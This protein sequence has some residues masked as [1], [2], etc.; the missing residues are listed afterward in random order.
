MKVNVRK[1]RK[2]IDNLKKDIDNVSMKLYRVR[3]IT[4]N[5]DELKEQLMAENDGL[6]LKYQDEIFALSDKLF[7][8]KAKLTEANETILH[9]AYGSMSVNSAI[10]LLNQ[11]GAFE[12]QMRELA[13]VRESKRLNTL[14]Q[15]ET[16]IK[17]YDATPFEEK[18]LFFRTK[19]EDL[20]EA[21]DTFNL[22]H[23]VEID[24]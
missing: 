20:Q 4:Y 24:D 8:L 13:S 16:T 15:Q 2:N 14:G 22:T 5:T 19:K 10:F 17:T 3:T 12:S 1:I 6:V 9:T 18:A 11:C 7:K 21:I 23:M